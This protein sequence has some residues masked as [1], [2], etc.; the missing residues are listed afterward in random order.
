MSESQASA[1]YAQSTPSIIM[2]SCSRG[3]LSDMTSRRCAMQEEATLMVLCQVPAAICRHPT[4]LP[5]LLRQA[6]ML[7]QAA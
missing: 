2:A 3:D 1:H 5:V 7:L 4:D 6:G